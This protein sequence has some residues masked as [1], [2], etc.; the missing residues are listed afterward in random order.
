MAEAKPMKIG[1]KVEVTGK[2]IVGTVAYIGQTLFSSGKWI[3]VVLDVPKG[4]NN[5]TVQGKTYFTCPDNHGIFV[6][7]SQITALDGGNGAA[8]PTPAKAAA[9]APASTPASKVPAPDKSEKRRSL[10]RPPSLVGKSNENLADAA[11]KTP[12]K[13]RSSPDPNQT[14]KESGIPKSRIPSKDS[15]P[16][17]QPAAIPKPTPSKPTAAKAAPA[18]KAPEQI[19]KAPAEAKTAVSPPQPA[20][21]T[22]IKTLEKSD[23]DPLTN[24]Q[25]T[26]E[27]EGL[28]AEIKDLNEKLETLKIKRGEDRAKL[29]DADKLKIQ[30]QQ[31]Q[32]YKHKMQETHGDLQRQ[33]Q[34]AKKDL[35]DTQ[36]AF[37]RYKE[38]MADT[39]ETIEIATLDKEMAEE[40]AEGLVQ[41]L[42]TVK[43][44]LEEVT[45]DLEIL[46]GEITDQGKEGV[47]A[48]Y[49]QKQLEQQNDRLK[50]ALVKMRDL[51]NQEKSECQNLTKQNEKMKNEINNYQKDKEKLQAE[52]SELHEQMIELKEQVDAALGA[53]E[54]VESLAEKNLAL[55]DEISKL[56][57]ENADLEVLHEMNEEIQENAR[58][59][60]LELREELDL[61]QSR[62]ADAYRKL[63]A[64]AE[65]CAD[66]EK[67]ITKFRELVKQLQDTNKELRSK[68]QE[69]EQKSVETPTIEFDFKARFAET[70]AYA[71]TIDMELRKLEVQ[72]ANAHVQMLLSFMPDTF[73]NRGGDHDAVSVLMMVPRIINKSELLSSQVKVKF[74]LADR[75]IERA[76]VLKSQK[77]EQ[78]SFAN[79]LVLLLDTLQA[80][81]K[82]YESALNNCSVE[83]FTKVGTL[84]PEMSAHEKSVD[85]FIDMLRKDQLDETVSLD[86]LEKSIGFFSQLYSVHLHNEKIDC[87]SLLADNVR[88]TLSASNCL[89]TDIARLKILIMPG[90]ENSEF[91]ILLRDLETCNNDTKMCARKIKRRLP[92]EGSSNTTPL[93]FNKEI[94]DLI[95]DASQQITNIS[96]T[97]QYVA[98]GAMQQASIMTDA[99]GLMPKKMEEL[100]YEA[101]DKVYSKDDSGPYDCLRL[102]FGKVAGTMNKL[103]NAMENGEYDFDGTHDKKRG[104]VQVTAPVKQRA[105]TV[106]GQ[107]ADIEV[108]KYKLDTKEDDIKELKILLKKKQEEMSEQQIRLG[109]L[110]KKLD[111]ASKDG[112][113]RVEKLQRKL[114]ELTIHAKKRE[115]DFDETCDSLQADIDALEQEKLDLRERL[116]VL[117][118]KS[119]LEGLDRKS[120]QTPT[121]PSSPLP[122]SLIGGV[123][124]SPL[125]LQQINSLKEALKFVKG[126]NIRLRSDQMKTIMDKLPPLRVPKKPTG[127]TSNT[128][129]IK[130]GQLPEA[131]QGKT[132]LNSLSRKT[133]NLLESVNKASACVKVIDITKRK[134]GIEPATDTTNPIKQLVDRASALTG[135]QRSTQELQV[136]ITNLLA[137]NRTGGQVR[138]DFSTFPTPQF[139]R[140]LHEKCG[141]SILAA[142]IRVPCPGGKGE[143]IPLHVTHDELRQIHLRFKS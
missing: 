76:D 102:S 32:E 48:T 143:K 77:A 90:Q 34:A 133:A 99:E 84:L 18:T 52:V 112:E 43:E 47:A 42:E 35:K 122:S 13:P 8:P 21:P 61:A 127:L 131:V 49:E 136:E 132:E 95:T 109:L 27:I 28:K 45:L 66:Y 98:V 80:I 60:E 104:Q 15:T 62:V 125:L 64:G 11:A 25:Q 86:L 59:M 92:Q 81:M 106:R 73:L 3:G 10:I 85:Y 114:D 124:D 20:I 94:H 38:E 19:V 137:A 74:E 68:Q 37:E 105:T 115:K 50:E 46:R 135:F 119:L 24:L 117:S 4:K 16:E 107:I 82:Q 111:N 57:E 39:S 134:A 83:L 7:Q 126:E 54:M 63:E 138:T 121:S 41:E 139:A 6:R 70:K 110:E 26:Q 40:K 31:L 129:M 58:E 9:P 93:R 108:M 79:R 113:E 97:L 72:Q 116:K 71:K 142:N 96:K 65:T 36:D 51:S 23:D 118:K 123:S 14:P 5:G 130:L 89:Y 88:L 22:D 17:P 56:R 120:G 100:A 128:G 141:E 55:E 2:G 140:M 1:S 33:L 30:L 12:A 103:A 29:K 53:E 69:S 67:T 78:I 44:K 91:S 87:T 101:V 75:T